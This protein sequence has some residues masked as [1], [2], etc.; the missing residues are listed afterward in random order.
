M[1]ITT[2]DLITITGKGELW[3]RYYLL[4]QMQ[5]NISFYFP[6]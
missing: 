4:M 2:I 1:L 6:T 3:Q 5:Q